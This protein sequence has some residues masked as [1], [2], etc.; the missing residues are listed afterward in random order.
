M[1]DLRKNRVPIVTTWCKIQLVLPFVFVFFFCHDA[2]LALNILTLLDP[3]TNICSFILCRDLSWQVMHTYYCD[4]ILP[5]RWPF[6]ARPTNHPSDWKWLLYWKWGQWKIWAWFVAGDTNLLQV[7]AAFSIWNRKSHVGKDAV[8][9]SVAGVGIVR[10]GLYLFKAPLWWDYLLELAVNHPVNQGAAANTLP[11]ACSHH[12]IFF[13]FLMGGGWVWE[14]KRNYKTLF[15][16]N[17][18]SEAFNLFSLVFMFM[19]GCHLI[20]LLNDKTQQ[21]P[22]CTITRT[23]GVMLLD[24][25]FSELHHS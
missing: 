16:G 2:S 3:W 9:G 23:A 25:V 7:L 13:F 8:G 21:P 19:F 10:G 18:I 22:A 11:L 20:C 24:G 14:E 1:F 6:H 4:H 15:I 12:L 5:S 17:Q